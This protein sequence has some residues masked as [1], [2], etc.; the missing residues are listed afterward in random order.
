MIPFTKQMLHEIILQESQNG[1]VS[2][3]HENRDGYTIW[4]ETE[5]KFI[6]FTGS[7]FITKDWLCKK[8]YMNQKLQYIL[9]ISVSQLAE[10]LLSEL[11][12]EY[13]Q[14]LNHLE[15]IYRKSDFQVTA[16]HLYG[17][18]HEPIYAFD[19]DAFW[20][21]TEILSLFEYNTILLNAGKLCK[22]KNMY[23]HSTEHLRYCFLENVFYAFQKMLLET[24]IFLPIEDYPLS[25][26]QESEL[27]SFGKN[28]AE[29]VFK[30]ENY[31]N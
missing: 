8:I 30:K 19:T 12:V 29:N 18:R 11:P 20:L 16:K 26:M 28:H 24:N 7:E 1:S 10:I 23:S 17:N 5:F 22:N 9:S 31:I 27:I 4:D 21:N 6:H 13:F 3:V 14:T 25:L 15:I 2:I